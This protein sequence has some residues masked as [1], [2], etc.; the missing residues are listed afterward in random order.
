MKRKDE[1]WALF[2]CTLLHPVLFGEIASHEVGAFLRQLACEI[3]R[4]H[5]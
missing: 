3:G 2:W 5:V 4:A 1:D